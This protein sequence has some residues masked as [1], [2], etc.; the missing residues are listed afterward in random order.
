MGVKHMQAEF[1]RLAVHHPTHSIALSSLG[2]KSM[3]FEFNTRF[4]KVKKQ[5]TRM[6]FEPMQPEHNELAVHHLIHSVSLS[7][8]GSDSMALEFTRRYHSFQYNTS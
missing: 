8:L 7:L 6:K 1:N 4:L 3:V 5:T 2:R